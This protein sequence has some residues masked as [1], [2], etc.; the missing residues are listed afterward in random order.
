MSKQA[1]IAAA[2]VAALGLQACAKQVDQAKVEADVRKAQAEGEKKIVD[3]QAKLEQVNAENNKDIV[4]AQ[5]DARLDAAKAAD[6]AA[7]PPAPADTKTAKTPAARAAA[8]KPADVTPPAPP[9]NDENVSKARVAAVGKV[10][11]AQYDVEKAKAEAAYSVTMAR[12]DGQTSD[13][14]QAVCRDGAKAV[15]DKA[16]ATAKA[17]KDAAHRRAAMAQNG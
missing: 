16:V 13:N 15:L 1:L 12:C 8:A 10:A 7:P 11:D 9:A 2:L 3:A 5:A 4:T 6:N 17:R 14:M